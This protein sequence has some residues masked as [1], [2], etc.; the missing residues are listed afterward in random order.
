MIDLAQD[1]N[2]DEK[3]MA[4]KKKAEKKQKKPPAATVAASKTQRE[5]FVF[6]YLQSHPSIMED[7]ATYRDAAAELLT[8]WIFKCYPVS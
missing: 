8:V 3:S 4:S 2:D 6:R 1:D 5:Q 7:V